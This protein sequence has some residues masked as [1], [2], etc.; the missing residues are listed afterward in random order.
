MSFDISRFI[1]DPW[2]DYYGVVMEQ[3]RVQLDS[4]WNE[5]LAELSRRIRAGTMDTLGR[6]V[7]PS[8]TPFAFHITASHDAAGNHIAIGAGRMYVDGL[9]AEN[10][11]PAGAAAWD[12]GLDEMSGAPQVAGAAEV[13]I[14][15]TKQPYLPG[16][17]L[18]P[19]NGPFLAYLDVWRRPVTYLE[20]P[21]LVDKAV[22]V[23]TTGRLQTVW[24]VKLLDVSAV[25][26]GVTCA[27]PDASIGP[28]KTLIQPSAGQLTNGVVAT[29]PS[30]P[31]CLTSNTGF[32]G[33][34]NQFYRVEIH[35]PGILATGTSTPYPL[36]A[37]SPTATFKWSRDNGSVQ[38]G[39]T[40]IAAVHNTAGNPAS[41]L[42]VLSLGRD[43]V[44]GF[45]PGNWIEITD[46]TLE[47]NGTHG[48]LHQIDSIDF[49]A[50]TIT[51]DSPVSAASFPTD[52][53]GQTDQSRH[54]R[55][56]RWDQAGKV[57]LSDGVT[58]W[59]DLGAAGATGDVP[60]PP[61]G[62]TLILENGITV[63]FGL[64]PST[65]ALYT[66]DYW[67][68]AARTADASVDPLTNAYPFGI[69]HHYARLAIVTFPSG[70]TDCRVEWPPTAGGGCCECTVNVSPADLTGGK[71]LQGILDQ[72]KNLQTIT[73]IC[74]MPGV[75]SLP[76]PLR[77]LPAYSHIH[78]KAA[79]PGTVTIQ[80]QPGR[81]SQFIDGMVVMDNVSDTALIGLNFL[82]P[83]A[84]FAAPNGTF[85]GLPLASLPPDVQSILKILVVSIGVRPVNCVGLTIE[86]CQFQFADLLKN[87]PNKFAFAVGIL[88]SGR[89][90]NFQ[91]T[92]TDFRAIDGAFVAGFLM[93]P[94]VAFTAPGAA[95]AAG[96][97]NLSLRP[98]AA[99]LS[100]HSAIR[101]AVSRVPEFAN[102][103]LL[104]S[105]PANLATPITSAINS[106]APAAAFSAA[107]AAN[108]GK[109]L[110][111]S[112]HES[113]FEG[114]SLEHPT[115]AALALAETG[116]VT[117]RENS[118]ADGGAGFWF[119]SP[120]ITS[121]VFNQGLGF[122]TT[123]VSIAMGYPLPQGDV[124]P[125]ANFIAVPPAPVPARIFAGSKNFTDSTGILWLPD[126]AAKTAVTISGGLLAQPPQPAPVSNAQPGATDQPLYQSER[127]GA[128]FTY[129]FPS[130]PL[131]FYQVTLK[132]AEIFYTNPSTNKGARVFNV[133]INGTQVLTDFDVVADVGGANV[134]DDQ[135]FPNIIPNSSGQIVIQFTGTTIGKDPN[136]KIGAVE[137]LPQWAAAPAGPD[138]ITFFFSQLA[139]LA[140]QAYTAPP[141]AAT[142]LR[143][144][145]NEMQRLASTGLLAL[146]TDVNNSS[147]PGSLLMSGNRIFLTT[148][149]I[150]GQGLI[151][152]VLSTAVDILAISRCVITGNLVWTAGIEKRKRGLL[153]LAVPAPPPAIMVSA[154]VFQGII[155]VEPEHYPAGSGVPAPMNS[156]AF[157]NTVLP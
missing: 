46:D 126:V 50:R 83:I 95:V 128:N 48:E 67:G 13:T 114:N 146:G 98:L 6:A 78:I 109:V 73:T 15:F 68:F 153:L 33:L 60:V 84:P 51:L 1:F 7:Y 155:L 120:A 150:S 79:Q 20:N 131:G 93:T 101:A 80:A 3:G 147:V 96:R 88:A 111:S 152:L 135:I 104:A 56:T 17:T 91:V 5:W 156:W 23:D 30:G 92:G 134:A 122:A 118:V 116:R 54:T 129:T 61:A 144:E 90:S 11:G 36:P 24:Q 87:A 74:L 29:A 149:E 130:L 142:A 41:Q 35:R 89:C 77:F 70:A 49:A 9:L 86:G 43:Q 137:V 31:C 47:L 106:G 139:E 64:N 63:K 10:H 133:A 8:T 143:V 99:A 2:N 117:F 123:G 138:E 65:G 28:W 34:E 145:A 58:V 132:F 75:Y 40:G 37:G 151:Q 44:L 18:P 103:N 26:G 97:A 66:G 4:D 125:A 81:E 62:T 59:V 127:Y 121:V 22:A 113:T 102:S 19:G 38:T 136:A 55:I 32:T 85:A 69:H 112:L 42:T 14:D 141:G 27:T 110:P 100:V 115:I 154:N 94:M 16:A 39:V 82:V 119:L 148:G 108:G 45:A 140:Q 53:Q 76:S 71:T 124:T 12:P 25:P 105:A 52:G 57:Y 157:L 72:F 107:L 21:R